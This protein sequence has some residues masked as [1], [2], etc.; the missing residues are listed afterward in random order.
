[1]SRGLRAGQG[2]VMQPGYATFKLSHARFQKIVQLIQAGNYIETACTAGGITTSSYARYLDR[3]RMVDYE[4]QA[5]L[6]AQGQE[7]D[8]DLDDSLTDEWMEPE[9]A[10]RWPLEPP[11]WLSVHPNDWT[12]W[13]FCRAIEKAQA[14]GEAAAVL[15]V[16]SHF[17]DNWA[18]AMT[19]LERK[20]PGR[21]R[22]RDE[23][24]VKPVL[25]A[26]DR[27]QDQAVLNSSDATALMHKALEA[28]TSPQ[29]HEALTS[30]QREPL[31]D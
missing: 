3:G 23:V 19:F 11:E 4:I 18:A 25:D 28:A 21:W 8:D 14:E 5:I 22:R 27:M 10:S 20:Y 1:M 12:C 26:S 7:L 13:L 16:K 6:R 9:A 17:G 2:R 15:A 31:D 30:T 29:T 24:T